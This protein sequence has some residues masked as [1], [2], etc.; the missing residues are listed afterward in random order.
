MLTKQDKKIVVSCFKIALFLIQI[1]N[2]IIRVVE[3]QD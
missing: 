1:C 3:R 2:T